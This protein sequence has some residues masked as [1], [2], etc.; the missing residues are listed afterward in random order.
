MV[1][2][3]VAPAIMYVYD[4]HG[5]EIL[6]EVLYDEPNEIYNITPEER[7]QH[8]SFLKDFRGA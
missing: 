4:K 7:E 1:T 3:P 8:A 2:T 5:F 6:S